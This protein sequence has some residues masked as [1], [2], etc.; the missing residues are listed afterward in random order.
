MQPDSYGSHGFELHFPPLPLFFGELV[1]GPKVESPEPVLGF[2]S[3]KSRFDSGLYPPEEPLEG[4][5]KL[6]Q[7]TSAH[8]NRYIPE[9]RDVPPGKGQFLMLVVE[10]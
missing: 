8:L 5:V 9:S 1:S 4:I 6:F 7:R 10:G 3:W 2:E